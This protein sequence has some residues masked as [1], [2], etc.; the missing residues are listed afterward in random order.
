MYCPR[1]DFFI[2]PWKPVDRAVIT[3]AHTD[4][5]RPGSRCYMAARPSGAILKHRLGQQIELQLL[6]YGE[7]T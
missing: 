7:P 2:D 6:D 1:G 5:A 3:H 4:H